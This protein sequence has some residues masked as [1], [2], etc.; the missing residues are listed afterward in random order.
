MGF[1]CACG[2][3]TL[4][5]MWFECMDCRRIRTSY[6][7]KNDLVYKKVH[8]NY[9]KVLRQMKKGYGKGRKL[10]NRKNKLSVLHLPRFSSSQYKPNYVKNEQTPS[11]NR[12]SE[13][14]IMNEFSET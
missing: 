8:A 13:Y 10:K 9:E 4:N 11:N 12:S 1:V 5:T 6:T 7:K 3:Y 2:N 14:K